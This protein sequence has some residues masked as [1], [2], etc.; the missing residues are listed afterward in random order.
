MGTAEE[1]GSAPFVSTGSLPDPERVQHLLHDA[2][3]RYLPDTG[4]TVS[5]VY[6]ALAAVDPALFGLA[7][8]SS[9]GRVYSAG[10]ALTPF[11][12][13]SVVKPFTFAMLCEDVGVAQARRLVGV[14]AT[15]LPFNSLA[16]VERAGGGRTN[17]MVNAGAIATVAALSGGPVE[18]RWTRIEQAMARFA[19][20]TLTVDSEIYASASATSQRNR[21]LAQLLSSLG[22]F[23]TDPAEA[24]DLYTRACCLSVT[25]QDLAAM[26]A[27]LADGGVH[28]LTRERV[29]GVES[30][31]AVLA[32]MT[33]SGLYETSGDWL[34]EIGLPGKSGIGGG[35]VT[36]SPG[37]GALATYSPPLDDAGNSVRGQR[38]SA[39]LSRSLGLDLFIS[40][41][42]NEPGQGSS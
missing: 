6:P 31:R 29:V 1:V 26:G 38:A 27:V 12:I 20:R 33:T 19:G 36:V 37:K 2:H 30:C 5:Q 41:P 22:S 35:I 7:V 14:N 17:P 25:A 4:G 28:P 16:A 32:V 8:V 13:M 23:S 42:M 10:D 40:A 18:Q 15:G 24:V 21:A 11:A 9:A 39:H 34:Y 3:G